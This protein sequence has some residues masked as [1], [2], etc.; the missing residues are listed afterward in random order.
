MN[1]PIFLHGLFRCG[2]TY[3]FNK[4]RSDDGVHC[5]YEPFHHVIRQLKK[6]NIDIWAHSG[7]TS[8]R[9]NH[10]LLDNPH[11]NEYLGAFGTEQV[12]FFNKRLSYD[13]FYL[14]EHATFDL[15]KIYIDYLIESS[16]EDKTVLL[17]FN[18]STF[19]LPFFTSTYPDSKHFFLLK[20]PRSQFL[21]YVH[22]GQIFLTINLIIISRLAR[23][24][25]SV[26]Y[27]V[28]YYTDDNI[29]KEILFYTGK[30][31]RI[32]LVD[33][34]RI[35]LF[36]W[37][38]SYYFALSANCTVIDTDRATA[39][40]LSN[41]FNGLLSDT[42]DFGDFKPKEPDCSFL[43][44]VRTSISAEKEVFDSFLSSFNPD[45]FRLFDPFSY[46]E[47]KPVYKVS[48]R[49]AYYKQVLKSIVLP[50]YRR[51]KSI[52]LPMVKRKIR[53]YI[54]SFFRYE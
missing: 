22:S 2:S 21:S 6:D 29:Q 7:K 24:G 16:P 37:C 4:F 5:Y 38:W 11:F 43:L 47:N 50:Y 54:Y 39:K 35:F 44:S 41:D 53:S 8:Q 1:D 51:L 13:R 48:L 15:E 3:L 33:H 25:F 40:S 10:P 23:Q 34:Y 49:V 17:Q 32:S 52:F 18:R 14:S 36:I 12:K 19:R 45:L 9:M 42:I 20:N 28:E 46:V 26:P 30:S 31:I 27:N